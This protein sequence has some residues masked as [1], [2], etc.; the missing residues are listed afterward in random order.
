M[1]SLQEAPMFDLLLFEAKLPTEDLPKF[2]AESDLSEVEFQTTDLNKTMDMWSVSAA[3]Q[4]FIHETDS[5]FIKD[6]KHPLGGYFKEVPKGI[7]RVEETKSVHFYKVF[8]GESKDYWVSFDALFR[9]GDLVSVDLREAEEVSREERLEA[10]KKAAEIA[11]RINESTTRKTSLLIRPIKF[12]I[13]LFLVSLHF[14]GS[15]ASKLHSKL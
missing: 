7:K 14:I 2:I 15:R 9:K 11:E 6:E 13:G 5:S 8:E 4:L 10:Q 1:I 12:L 3:G